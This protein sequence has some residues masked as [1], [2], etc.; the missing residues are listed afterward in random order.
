MWTSGVGYIGQHFDHDQA[1]E[2]GAFH[3]R[4]D[5][6]LDE[7]I[8]EICA[9]S[10]MDQRKRELLRRID[11]LL[12]RGGRGE[13]ELGAK[14]Q[15]EMFDKRLSIELVAPVLKFATSR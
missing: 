15:T 11:R 5:Y 9:N 10:V 12:W 14:G 7:L 8:D 3:Y 6:Y 1:W 2:K 4:R 13:D